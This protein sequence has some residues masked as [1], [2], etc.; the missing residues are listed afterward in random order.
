MD[1]LVGFYLTF[2]FVAGADKTA[3]S[4]K[5]PTSLGSPTTWREFSKRT[6]RL[7]SESADTEFNLTVTWKLGTNAGRKRPVNLANGSHS[8]PYRATRTEPYARTAESIRG[9][10][11]IKRAESNRAA[12]FINLS[13][14]CLPR[15]CRLLRW[16]L[17][18][19]SKVNRRL[20][21]AINSISIVFCSPPP[22]LCCPPPPCPSCR[23]P[24]PP[25]CSLLRLAVV[26]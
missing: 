20:M 22:P 13:R 5:T 24:R 3:I 26:V 18:G 11:L 23:T 25:G 16:Q 1:R 14:L 6:I 21:I 17:T 19:V 8:R 2:F 10:H 7:I 9:P 4:K 12:L 15:R